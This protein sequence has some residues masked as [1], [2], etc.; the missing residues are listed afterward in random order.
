[1]YVMCLYQALPHAKVPL[2]PTNGSGS[3]SKETGQLLSTDTAAAVSFHFLTPTLP[4]LICFCCSLGQ[5]ILQQQRPGGLKCLPNLNGRGFSVASCSWRSPRLCFFHCYRS[6]QRQGSISQ[7]RSTRIKNMLCSFIR[8]T[9]IFQGISAWANI[10]T[11]E[12]CRSPAGRDS[13]LERG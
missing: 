11:R 10:T 6:K 4:D 2:V 5:S 9:F 3:P 1:M 12:R 8:L 13:A 7:A